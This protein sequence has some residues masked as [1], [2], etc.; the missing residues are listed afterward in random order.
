[1]HPVS[2][3]VVFIMIWWTVIFCVLPFGV[4][5]THEEEGEDGEYI[6]PGAPKNINIKKK[7]MIT[8]VISIIIWIAVYFFIESNIIDIREIAYKMD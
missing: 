4:S 1:M 2:A 7:F 8:T 3:I 6:A 5:T